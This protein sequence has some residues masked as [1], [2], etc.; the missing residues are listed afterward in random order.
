MAAQ[1]QALS[2]RTTHCCETRS[3]IAPRGIASVGK[4]VLGKVMY[5]FSESRRK[6]EEARYRRVYGR[7][8]GPKPSK[9]DST[10]RNGTVGLEIETS[11]LEFETYGLEIYTLGL[12]LRPQDSKAIPYV[13][14]LDLRT[15][16]LCRRSRIQTGLISRPRV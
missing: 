14:N 8:N 10:S 1:S 6:G 15:R 11:G 13:S 5:S 16:N 12:E 3:G 4:L 9:S 2:D 7:P